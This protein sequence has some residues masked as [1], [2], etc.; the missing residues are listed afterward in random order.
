MV[1]KKS[2]MFVFALAQAQQDNFRMKCVGEH[3]KDFSHVNHPANHLKDI[4]LIR[5][6]FNPVS[7][8]PK[9]CTYTTT[10]IIQMAA[11]KRNLSGTMSHHPAV[12]LEMPLAVSLKVMQ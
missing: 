11:T 12:V 8:L 7:W 3:D 1:R 2:V 10:I 9:S 4:S 5:S 6:G